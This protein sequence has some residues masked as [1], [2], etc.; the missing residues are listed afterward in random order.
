LGRMWR[1]M[2]DGVLAPGV[3]APCARYHLPAEGSLHYSGRGP[4]C[5]DCGLPL[6][7]GQTHVLAWLAPRSH[8]GRLFHHDCYFHG[9]P[10]RRSA[11]ER[12]KEGDLS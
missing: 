3:L 7:S 2:P 10:W 11:A 9:A 6:G 1:A 4:R 12:A 8:E 5:D